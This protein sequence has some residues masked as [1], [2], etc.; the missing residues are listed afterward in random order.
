MSRKEKMG[1]LTVVILLVSVTCIIMS[2][3]GKGPVPSS[4]AKLYVYP[5]KIEDPTLSPSSTFW[6]NIMVYNITNMLTCQ[7]NL[8]FNPAVLTVSAALAQRVQGQYPSAYID[9]NSIKGYVYAKLTYKQPVTLPN[10]NASVLAI[11]FMVKNYGI[12]VL[13]LHETIIKDSN[14]NAIPHEATDGL[15]RIIKR[16]IAVTD[17]TLSTNETYI[18]R[19]VTINV[20]VKNKGSIA[21]NV[22]VNVFADGNNIAVLAIENLAPDETRI[23][24][25][26]WNTS[27]VSPSK[28]PYTVKAESIA[29][30]NEANTSDNL[31]IDGLIKI[32]IVGDV[33]GD[34]I[35]NIDDL[36]IWDSAYNSK[37]GEP[38]WKPQADING[39]NEVNNEDGILII[40]NYQKKL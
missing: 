38:N 8:S 3:Y 15:V 35:V 7:F 27:S 32:K 11:Q 17:V 25:F 30:P 1:I 18:N 6:I 24:T 22:T 29:L 12:T 36:I 2:Q 5:E 4:G 21:E 28:T 19:N 34:G 37:I 16:D 9:A 10:T 20:T 33:N 31:F 40:Q 14:G 39:D 13:D 26:P 23:L